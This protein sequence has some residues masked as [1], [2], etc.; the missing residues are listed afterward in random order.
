MN[1]LIQIYQEAVKAYLDKEYHKAKKF[2]QT[3]LRQYIYHY[4]EAT[5]V[6]SLSY[7]LD[8]IL[9]LHSKAWL[10]I[11]NAFYT[12]EFLSE[13]QQQEQLSKAQGLL[14][15]AEILFILL[16][17]KIGFTQYPTLKKGFTSLDTIQKILERKTAF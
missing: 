9:A 6:D 8:S 12:H 7:A 13:I 10:H 1:N 11:N 16:K 2:H 5:N 4:A 14:T 15:G 17:N 3:L